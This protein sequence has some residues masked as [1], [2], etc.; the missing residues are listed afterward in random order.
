LDF[1]AVL[2]GLPGSL[3]RQTFVAAAKDFFYTP[4]KRW[5]TRF[6]AFHTFAFDRN[7]H[8]PQEY[9]R[10][11]ACLQQGLSLVIFPEGS[12][13]RDGRLQN[14]K[15]IAAMLAA[16]TGVPLLPVS[17][18]GT[19]AALPPGRFWPRRHP[20]CVTFAA[21]IATVPLPGESFHARIHRINQEL[22]A[23]IQRLKD[24]TSC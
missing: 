17:V 9:R 12:R 5:L 3:R 21:P 14:L 11:G 18:Q 6:L 22:L 16:D 13:S 2:A 24:K 23:R 8:S 15:P 20:I 4:R 10:L 19:H 7:V 1:W